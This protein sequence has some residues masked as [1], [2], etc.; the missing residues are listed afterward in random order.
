MSLSTRAAAT[1]GAG[2]RRV[3][4][5]N[6]FIF[7]VA[8]TRIGPKQGAVVGTQVR[9]EPV[10]RRR[11]EHRA[12]AKQG[13]GVVGLESDLLMDRLPSAGARLVLK[14][15]DRLGGFRLPMPATLLV[16]EH[17]DA[18]PER[19]IGGADRLLVCHR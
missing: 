4:I 1:R 11:I 7:V 19:L 6:H 17:G 5:G 2:E 16:L 15:H 10:G 9:S 8:A 12:D 14:A 3:G 18:A 13:R